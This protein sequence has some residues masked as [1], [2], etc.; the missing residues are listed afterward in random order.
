[1]LQ[2][3]EPHNKKTLSQQRSMTFSWD[4]LQKEHPIP[5]RLWRYDVPEGAG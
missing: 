1:M 3:R 2:R 4:L 5:I